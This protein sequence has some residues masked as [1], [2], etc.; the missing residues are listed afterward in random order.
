MSST[1]TEPQT[2]SPEHS[3]TDRA[4]DDLSEIVTFAVG[5]QGFCIEI[6]HVLEIR[7][8]TK[9]TVLPHAPDY[10]VGLMNLRG[11]VLPVIDL[12]LRLGLGKTETTPRHVIIITHVQDRTLGLLVEAVSDILSVRDGEMKPTPDV[13]SPQ[14]RAFI[15]GVYSV[16]ESLVRAID[17]HQVVPKADGLAA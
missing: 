1:M 15:R 8:W 12:S 7:G 4:G 3:A 17:V 14:T 13:A 5:K 11:T 16:A 2:A 9:T 10:V 6:E